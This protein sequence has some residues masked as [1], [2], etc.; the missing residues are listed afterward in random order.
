MRFSRD[1]F[2]VSA[3][4][5]PGFPMCRTLRLSVPHG[6][7]YGET[8]PMGTV[9][10]CRCE[11]EIMTLHPN[12]RNA[13]ASACI[14]A[15]I[16]LQTVMLLALFTRTAP[17]PP[18]TVPPF[19]LGP[20]LGMAISLGVFA[21]ILI[22]RGVKFGYAAAVGFALASLVSFGPQKLLADELSRIWPAVLFGMLGAFTLIYVSIGALRGGVSAHDADAA[23]GMPG[24]DGLG[25]R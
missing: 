3:G 21:A 23:D 22:A 1:F 18:L 24:A 8:V 9:N 4:M 17:H 6:T 13:T 7:E 12:T 16:T 5:P 11:V 2:F 14:W 10:Q 25:S 15:L 20:F 19:A